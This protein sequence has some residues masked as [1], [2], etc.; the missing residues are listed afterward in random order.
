MGAGTGNPIWSLIW[1]IILI[2]L[3]F[4]IAGLCAGLYIF[5]A[6]FSVCIKPLTSLTELLMKGVTLTYTSADNMVHGNSL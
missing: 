1:L 2:F 4:P 5:I 3:A 6:P